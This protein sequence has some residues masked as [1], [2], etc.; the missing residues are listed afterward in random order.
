MLWPFSSKAYFYQNNSNSYNSFNNG[1]VKCFKLIMIT[2]WTTSERIQVLRGLYNL[3][4]AFE[5]NT[6]LLMYYS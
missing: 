2:N 4:S 1:S 5:K 6:A 3:G